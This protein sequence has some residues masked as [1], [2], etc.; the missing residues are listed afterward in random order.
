MTEQMLRNKD[1]ITRYKT[2]IDL[3]AYLDSVGYTPDKKH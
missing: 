1:L 2:D 3:V